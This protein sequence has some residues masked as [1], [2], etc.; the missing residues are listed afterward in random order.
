MSDTT[1][2]EVIERLAPECSKAQLTGNPASIPM[3]IMVSD[4]L[5]LLWEIAE[6]R[7]DRQEERD[8]YDA[9]LAERDALQE[10][11]TEIRYA[12][13]NPDMFTST[14]EKIASIIAAALNTQP[15]PAPQAEWTPRIDDTVFYRDGVYR[16][17]EIRN[18]RVCLGEAVQPELYP[19][20]L[21]VDDINELTPT[22]DD[23]AAD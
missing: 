10:A 12:Q 13:Q 2:D 23:N 5:A 6:L 3:Q 9:V 4:V 14:H 21:W 8:N 19:D 1:V 15:A 7:V 11:L 18:G 22:W 20:Q 17:V 16:I